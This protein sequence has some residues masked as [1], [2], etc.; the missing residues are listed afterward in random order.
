MQKFRFAV[1]NALNLHRMTWAAYWSLPIGLGICLAA[2]GLSVFSPDSAELAQSVIMQAGVI[3]SMFGVFGLLAVAAAA[4]HQSWRHTWRTAPDADHIPDA[5]KKALPMAVHSIAPDVLVWRKQDESAADFADRI[6]RSKQVAN[7]AVWVVV[8]PYRSQVVTVVQD[9]GKTLQ[10]SRG[11]EP[12]QTD[13]KEA[14]HLPDAYD[15]TAETQSEYH[16][17]LGWFCA[18][19]RKYSEVA[20]V[21]ERA[22][23]DTVIKLARVSACVVFLFFSVG[24][25]AQS[26]ARQVDEALGTRI[27]EIPKPGEQVEFVFR[28]NGREKTYMGHGDGRKEYTE[29]LQ[30]SGTGLARYSDAGGTLLYVRKSGEVVAK[31]VAVGDVATGVKSPYQFQPSTTGDPVRPRQ[32]PGM[33]PAQPEYQFRAPDSLEIAERL[34]RAKEN[35]TGW[36]EEGWRV[37][38]PVWDFAMWL[39]SSIM[40]LL[41]CAIILF[42]YVAQTAANESL[43]TTYGRVIMGRW[44]VSAQQN[45]AAAT[46]VCTWVIFVTALLNAFL[47]MVK[48]GLPMWLLIPVAFVLEWIAS[49]VTG[50]IVPNIRF[51]SHNGERGLNPFN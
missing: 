38:S 51:V 42:R 31:G 15:C 20:K 29:I 10:F 14:E 36:K 22:G 7:D 44:I 13:L 1:Q 48:A 27:R 4:V 32:M 19:W 8:C 43:V 39:F 34:E 35:I 3:G 37:V 17:Y 45:S 23:I 25:S 46:L 6:A 30:S 12:F 5:G 9:G 18:H 26:K 24:I 21:A 50:W 33:E 11:N 2:L 49:K 41:V 40:V 28:E 47:W 16:R